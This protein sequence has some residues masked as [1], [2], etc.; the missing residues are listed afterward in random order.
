M[1]NTHSP[2]LTECRVQRGKCLQSHTSLWNHRHGARRASTGASA[3]HRRISDCREHSS[4]Q[5]QLLQLHILGPMTEHGRTHTVP[6]I[7]GLWLYRPQWNVL[8]A[9]HSLRLFPFLPHLSSFTGARPA[10]RSEGSPH[11]FL[12]LQL[13]PWNCTCI[14]PKKILCTSNPFLASAPQGI[15]VNAAYMR[16]TCIV[17]TIREDFWG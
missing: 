14:S 4:W 7:G 3:I 9:V 8:G 15:W 10:L 5:S 16:G 2:F 13:L 11:R 12:L 1:E 17:L 6:L